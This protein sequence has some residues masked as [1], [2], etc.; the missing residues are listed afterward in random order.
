[1]LNIPEERKH[2]FNSTAYMIERK[3]LDLQTYIIAHRHSLRYVCIEFTTNISEEELL[4]IEKEI[5]KMYDLL[6]AFCNEYNVDKLKATMQ[7]ELMVKSNFLWEDLTGAVSLKGYGELDKAIA[8]DYTKK[9]NVMIDSI[10]QLIQ[11]L[12]KKF[13]Y[14]NNKS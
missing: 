13:N 9:M 11:Q 12:T 4:K 5:N 3:L 10:N 6:E 8:D 2:I 1:M 7:S 14:A